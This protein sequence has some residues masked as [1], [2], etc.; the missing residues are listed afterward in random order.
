[1]NEIINMLMF[2][3][4][5]YDLKSV[6]EDFGAKLDD[7]EWPMSELLN[8]DGT[9]YM[10]FGGSGFDSDNEREMR[11]YLVEVI[12]WETEE[13]KVYTMP[14]ANTGFDY[15]EPV[16]AKKDDTFVYIVG[17]QLYT[18]KDLTTWTVQD[19][20]DD[21]LMESDENQYN[22]TSVWVS[23]DTVFVLHNIFGED[24]L[25]PICSEIF[26]TTDFVNYTCLTDEVDENLTSVL[27]RGKIGQ[28]E[29]FLFGE[30][31]NFRSSDWQG[32]TYD[33][34][35]YVYIPESQSFEEITRSNIEMKLDDGDVCAKT[36]VNTVV[37]NPGYYQS[38][39]YGDF[40]LTLVSDNGEIKAKYEIPYSIASEGSTDSLINEGQEQNGR[41]YAYF[42]KTI[43]T[44]DSEAEKRIS[45]LLV[46]DNYF[47]SYYVF[48]LPGV[49]SEVYLSNDKTKLV[50]SGTVY[51]E[52]T[53]DATSEIWT[54]DWNKIV[55]QFDN[56]VG[57]TNDE[58]TGVS[59][60][61]TDYNTMSSDIS[62]E[63]SELDESDLVGNV[64]PEGEYEIYDITLMEDGKEQQP[65]EGTKVKVTI[66]VPEGYNGEEMKIYRAE[67][68][69][70][71]TDMNATYDEETNTLVYYTEHFSKYLIAK[72]I[73]SIIFG[74]VNGDG[75]VN[76]KDVTILERYVAK[77]DDVEIVD[78][79]SDLNSDG[80]INAKGVTILARYIA[81]WAEYI[82]LPFKK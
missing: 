72:G 25:N 69:G 22:Q 6:L 44:Y 17:T 47:K 61:T 55:E 80:L 34:G 56:A 7:V 23:D 11:G 12:D 63:V 57:F 3:V 40:V 81:K 9:C 64:K 29:A 46:T 82:S 35:F 77:W 36:I 38:L 13:F 60:D 53:G 50:A 26:V 19:N 62:L 70:T 1:M 76:A 31:E 54:C 30:T 42:I 18:S 45:K 2:L 27:N 67:E 58:V 33:Y 8:I 28:Y 21:L 65:E 15:Y 24:G 5:E 74:D 10:F 66:D 68:D 71:Y 79:N 20:I 49:A 73:S 78:E 48:D 43:S 52:E 39:E 75:E 51:D 4:E 16:L 59:V 32:Y 14:F 41:K 37:T